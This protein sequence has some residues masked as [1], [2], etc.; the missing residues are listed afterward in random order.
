MYQGLLFDISSSSNLV[1][2]PFLSTAICFLVN[3]LLTGAMSVH[4][5]KPAP[6]LTGSLS[7]GCP[8]LSLEVRYRGLLTHSVIAMGRGFALR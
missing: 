5:R 1:Q 2:G 4:Q 6:S 8:L 3:G 7:H